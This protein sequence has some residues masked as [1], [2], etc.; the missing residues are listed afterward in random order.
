MRRLLLVFCLYTASARA[1]GSTLQSWDYIHDL[2]GQ[3]SSEQSISPST[4]QNYAYDLRGQLTQVSAAAGETFTYDHSGNRLNANGNV[5]VIVASN[6]VESDG[7]NTYGYDEEGNLTGKANATERW[8]YSYDH[9]NRLTLAR[10][11]DQANVL[12]STVE[13]SYDVLDRRIQKSVSITNS[14]NPL[15]TSYDYHGEMIWKETKPSGTTIKYLV[16]DGIDQWLARSVNGQIQWFLSDRM[17]SIQAVT[18]DAGNILESYS[19]S[20]FGQR[21]TTSTTPG[22]VSNEI[23]FTG[24]EHDEETGLTYYRARY[25]DPVLGR[26]TSEDPI[27]FR[28]GDFNLSRYVEN[29]PLGYL[30]PH[31]LSP[32]TETQIIQKQKAAEASIIRCL[33]N[34]ALTNI[35]EAGIYILL[36][37]VANMPVKGPVN[38][39]VGK[40]TR[41]F[42]IRFF[43]HDK[44]GKKLISKIRLA[45]GIIDSAEKLALAEQLVMEEFGGRAKLV[46]QKNAASAARFNR[47]KQ[48]FC[49]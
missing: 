20:A 2:A 49:Q 28:A 3:L 46:N 39:Y 25:M 17:G 24:R 23:G 1:D 32:L 29:R 35:G 18:D 22:F 6:R 38:T 16:G 47:L 13:F 10:K 36:T 7:V 34:A 12:Q 21:S 14:P 15:I 41:T 44:P 37:N 42:E 40:T 31:G 48:V 5:Y 4:T 9:R 8:A 33:G 26:F 43:E 19:Y 27:G 11:F 45:P 30:D